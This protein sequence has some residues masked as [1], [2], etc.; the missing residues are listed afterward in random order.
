MGG[1]VWI[2]LAQDRDKHHVI[3]NTVTELSDF[4]K[5]QETL[6]SRE[7]HSSVVLLIFNNVNFVMIFTYCNYMLY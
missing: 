7:V 3:V 5:S 2:R 6:A 1:G 4:I